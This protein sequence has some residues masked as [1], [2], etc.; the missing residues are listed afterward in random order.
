MTKKK[1]WQSTDLP[2]APAPQAQNK[3]SRAELE[4]V[5]KRAQELVRKNPE[6]AAII[7]STW[8]NEKKAQK[9]SKKAA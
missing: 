2:Q 5:F 3:A 8:I 6:K 4:L 1:I 9:S 7:L